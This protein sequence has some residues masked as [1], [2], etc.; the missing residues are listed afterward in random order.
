MVMPLPSEPQGFEANRTRKFTRM[1]GKIWAR[2]FFVVPI[3]FQA[4]CDCFL[5]ETEQI[6]RWYESHKGPLQNLGDL[7]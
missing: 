5:A 3:L 1:L 2:D 4:H 7:G 6:S